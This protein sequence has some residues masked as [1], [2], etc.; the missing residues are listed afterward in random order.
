VEQ[1]DIDRLILAAGPK[2]PYA[3]KKA[4]SS[5]VHLQVKL[6]FKKKP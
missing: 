3:A 5:L 6:F 1:K 4:V 2:D